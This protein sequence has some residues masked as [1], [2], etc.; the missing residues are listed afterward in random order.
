VIREARR[1]G[2]VDWLAFVT[3]LVI[4]VLFV[5]FRESVAS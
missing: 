1:W 3:G 2:R 4:E 5:L